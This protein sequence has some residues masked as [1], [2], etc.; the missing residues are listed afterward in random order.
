[1]SNHF[2][3]LIN[4]RLKPGM[5]TQLDTSRL[6]GFPS[7][8]KPLKRFLL[9]SVGCTGL[10]PGVNGSSL[11][12]TFSFLLALLTVSLPAASNFAAQTDDT[13]SEEHTSELQSRE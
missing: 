6:S 12:K 8:P 2:A 1:M 11:R 9:T 10:K 5:E 13:R 7:A 4:T 3:D